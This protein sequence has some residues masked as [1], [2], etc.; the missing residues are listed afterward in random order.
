MRGSVLMPSLPASFSWFWLIW[1]YWERGLFLWKGNVRTDG[2]GVGILVFLPGEPPYAVQFPTDWEQLPCGRALADALATTAYHIS[3]SGCKISWF[4]GGESHYSVPLCIR[5]Q[6][7]LWWAE[8]CLFPYL[9]GSQRT[10]RKARALCKPVYCY[11]CPHRTL[12]WGQWQASW[13]ALL[14]QAVVDLRTMDSLC[15]RV[16]A[17]LNTGSIKFA[18]TCIAKNT[19]YPHDKCPHV[20]WF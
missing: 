2:H 20:S 7:L 3:S 16:L 19:A 11:I 1:N 15:L 12:D 5:H 10:R 4:L 8:K 18:M 6:Q 9:R 17:M 14:G 13:A